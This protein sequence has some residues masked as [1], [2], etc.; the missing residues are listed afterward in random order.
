MP[1]GKSVSPWE[2]GVRASMVESDSV[3]ELTGTFLSFALRIEH[4]M[5]SGCSGATFESDLKRLVQLGA[6][7]SFIGRV[8]DGASDLTPS[9]VEGAI[10]GAY[11]EELATSC[12]RLYGDYVIAVA[13]RLRPLLSFSLKAMN[14]PRDMIPD[15]VLKPMARYF[16]DSVRTLKSDPNVFNRSDVRVN[17]LAVRPYSW[18]PTEDSLSTSMLLLI[19]RQGRR[20]RWPNA[21][22]YSPLGHFL[23]SSGLAQIVVVNRCKCTRCRKEYSERSLRG[24][25]PE[26]GAPL[27]KYTSEHIMS[28]RRIENSLQ[29]KAFETPS[30]LIEVSPASVEWRRRNAARNDMEPSSR[31]EN[32]QILERAWDIAID[33][34]AD[35]WRRTVTS[36]HPKARKLAI[37]CA[38]AGIQALHPGQELMRPRRESLRNI[39]RRL[40]EEDT[41]REVLANRARLLL[42]SVIETLGC[43]RATPTLASGA[44]STIIS[45]IKNAILR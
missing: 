3:R 29:N 23:R 13:D 32:S 16:L 27:A 26:C 6:C 5:L 18:S 19:V 41:R 35:V 25:C 36:R 21:L 15:D 4:A 44:A 2:R 1:N 22:M 42:P 40:L 7:R 45:R 30:S 43:H 20:M 8:C 14:I 38:L 10:A 37:L 33:R 34:A 28:T 17:R 11:L 31:L 9:D 24:R 39:V 12:G